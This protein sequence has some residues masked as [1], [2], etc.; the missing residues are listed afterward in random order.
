M[1]DQSNNKFS[2]TRF[3]ALTARFLATHRRLMMSVALA[4]LGVL[5]IYAFCCAKYFG[6][7]WKGLEVS[8][9][10]AMFAFYG[11][12]M[13]SLTFSS[14]KTKESRISAMMFPATEA[15]KFVMQ[16]MVY[17][18][19]SGLIFAGA[20]LVA[21]MMV[22]AVNHQEPLALMITEIWR[23]INFDLIFQSLYVI[24]LNY[25]IFTLGSALWPRFSFLKTFCAMFII[26]IGLFTVIPLESI[27]MSAIIHLSYP[28]IVTLQISS[29]VFIYYMAWLR[30]RHT[31]LTD[32]LL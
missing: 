12:I 1:I 25:A 11:M 2:L 28:W 8:G 14:L 23:A 15:E 5:T 6:A 27:I 20:A 26:Q 3:T 24:A 7:A 10:Y 16:V 32:R 17:T 22:S 18:V 13:G 31:Q 9:F 29:I 19:M 30:F 21:D 4:T